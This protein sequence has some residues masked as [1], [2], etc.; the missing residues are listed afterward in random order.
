MA[1]NPVIK[2][3]IQRQSVGDLVSPAPSPQEL[4][5]ILQA[6]LNVPD[7]GRLQPVRFH[8]FE[9]TSRQKFG[10]GLAESGAEDTPDLAEKVKDKIRDKA[11][12]APVVIALVCATKKGRIPRWEQ[13]ATTACAG[14]AM[15]LAATSMGYGAIWKSSVFPP[16]KAL[17][18]LLN[19]EEDASLMGWINL[20]TPKEGATDKEAAD[21]GDFVTKH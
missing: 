7:H 19:M 6:A 11:F 15:T 2:Q 18:A 4:D 20:G 9:G 3:M 13:E 17:K 16:G 8:I 14:Y 5:E 1:E 10:D 12:K 21:I